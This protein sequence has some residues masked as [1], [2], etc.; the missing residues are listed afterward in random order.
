MSFETEARIPGERSSSESARPE[1]SYGRI[2]TSSSLIGGSQVIGLVLGL[3]RAKLAAL[4][5]GAE[6]VGL[7]ALLQGI[8]T[9]G[10]TLCGFGLQ[11][12]GAR[13]VAAAYADNNRQQ[14]ARTV[15]LIRRLAWWTGG[16]GLVFA[17]C[18]A[19]AISEFNF[20]T[21]D[22][23]REIAL[24]GFAILLGNLTTSESAAIQGTR[25]IAQLAK[26][27]IWSGILGTLLTL[28]CYLWLGINGVAPALVAVAGVTW[29][30]TRLASRSVP[31]EPVSL[32]WGE[33]KT[34][35]KHLLQLG[36]ALA[37]NGIM[38]S[39][40]AYS[41]RYLINQ[42]HGLD[43]VGLFSAAFALSG[44]FVGFVLSAMSADFYPA[45]TARAN[46]FPRMVELINQQTQVALL[47]AF[48][49]LLGTLIL[50]PIGLTLFYS[51]EFAAAEDLLRWFIIGCF[52]RVLSWPL[53]YCILAQGN[54]KLF[55][56][57]ETCFNALHLVLV[58]LGLAF[59]SLTSVAI[60][61]AAAN[62]LYVLG[63]LLVTNRS[64]GF[65]WS[66]PI[67][68]QL[69]WMCPLG[70]IGFFATSLPFDPPATII[71]CLSTVLIAL[72]CLRQ[73]TNLVGP[74]HPVS[75]LL[76]RL[77]K[78]R[79]K[80]QGNLVPTAPRIRVFHGLVNYG[81]QAG[82]LARA[83]RALGCDAISV[84]YP[85]AF[86]R[87]T[88]VQLRSGGNLFQKVG[89]HLWN[90][91]FQLRCFF[92]YDIF[93]FYYGTSLLPRQWDLPFYHM[94]GKQVI[95][96]YL[97]NDIQSY[98]LS[99]QKYRWTN[100]K[101]MMSPE[102]GK[103]ADAKIKRRLAF[104]SQYA[105]R[106]LVCAP[107]YSEFAPNS[108]VLPLA[109]DL[110]ELPLR[111]FP[112]FEGV[113][114]LLHA[115]TDRNFKGTKFIIEAIE[116]LISGGYPVELTIAENISHAELLKKYHECHLFIDQI[117]GGW[118][119]TAAIEAMACGRPVVCSIRQS[120][121]VHIG[122]GSQI[123]IIDADPDT[124]YPALAQLLD[125]GIEELQKLGLR[126]RQFVEQVHDSRKVATE[127]LQIYES[128][129][130]PKQF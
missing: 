66:A 111:R 51:P 87:I 95:L 52:G 67:R 129:R 102:E 20:G 110:A 84:T 31:L 119:G 86:Q 112:N 13:E 121:F 103:A 8:M 50:A 107:V 92:R 56:F 1:D 125:R 11:Q 130:R 101:F 116:K 2:V 106:T 3:F 34:Q 21:P 114:K 18:F 91:W 85:D 10:S 104:E 113:F 63:M 88:D 53:G 82:I 58:W 32:S 122:Y 44:M 4:L 89:R 24:L 70:G 47:L 33:T 115:P 17:V 117:L 36:F 29:G 9:L 76:Q 100:V 19:T 22:H 27:G 14:L 94:F 45:L 69:A 96:E 28:G 5:I 71:G 41:T 42:Y 108:T 16:L 7:N 46:D 30:L 126:S 80:G 6:G 60:A 15:H 12:S 26:V 74:N 81:T 39:G 109:I 79:T 57:V 49:G 59:S 75:R 48:P 127:L 120:Y 68:R 123:P 78:L 37:I 23:G 97:G 61:F 99:I 93:H 73:I 124:I 62:F 77:P 25:Q 65:S 83:L 98:E 72:V 43:G 40:V 54:G 90:Y 118:Y 35:T 105:S 38:V 55:L 128:A 64:I